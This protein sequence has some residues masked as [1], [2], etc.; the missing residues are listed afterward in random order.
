[1]ATDALSRLF[2][3]H[4]EA[5]NELIQLEDFKSFHQFCLTK[6][7]GKKLEEDDITAVVIYNF[8]KN[9]VSKIIPPTDFSFPREEKSE[10]IPSFVSQQ[11][12][13]LSASEMQHI[14]NSVNQIN[15][16]LYQVK[17]SSKSQQALLLALG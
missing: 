8:S 2:L 11:Q 1:M 10:F 7:E 16:E 3:E 5:I 9:T 12:N 15:H 13:E 17:R 4:P 14:T 6:W